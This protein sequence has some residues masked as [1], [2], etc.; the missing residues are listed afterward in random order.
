MPC[1]VKSSLILVEPCQLRLLFPNG[2]P[3]KL[4][5]DRQGQNNPTLDF[6]GDEGHSG[7]DWQGVV[8][9]RDLPSAVSGGIWLPPCSSPHAH[10]NPIL[11]FPAAATTLALALGLAPFS[12]YS[13]SKPPIILL[14]E[15]NHV[16]TSFFNSP[17]PGLS[18]LL[19]ATHQRLQPHFLLAAHAGR[20]LQSNLLTLLP[21]LASGPHHYWIPLLIVT[22]LI[23]LVQPQV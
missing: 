6:S 23:K 14:P 22:C 18:M 20:T 9:P 2:C 17:H 13:F 12:G 3:T 21:L 19:G 1:A 8:T 7:R 10:S 16:K 4:P 15:Y 11:S 5:S